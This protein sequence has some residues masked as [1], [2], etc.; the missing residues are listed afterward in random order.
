MGKRKRKPRA[1]KRQHQGKRRGATRHLRRLKTSHNRFEWTLKQADSGGP[2][3]FDDGVFRDQWC[4]E[5]LPKLQEFEAKGWLEIAKGV[6]GKKGGSPNHPVQVDDLIEEAQE[7][8]QQTELEL[9]AELFSVRLD[10]KQRLFGIVRDS[11]L[12]LLWHDP[13]HEICPT[14]RR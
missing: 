1:S 13:H 9:A 7:R 12:H 10:D 11:V 4:C 5:I 8:L 14:K 6:P 2:W 3:G